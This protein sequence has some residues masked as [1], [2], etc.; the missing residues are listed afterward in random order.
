VIEPRTRVFALVAKGKGCVNDDS[1]HTTSVRGWVMVPAWQAVPPQPIH[2][3]PASKEISA[4]Q[5]I[6]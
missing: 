2:V 3:A 6:G 1:V 4:T 5:L